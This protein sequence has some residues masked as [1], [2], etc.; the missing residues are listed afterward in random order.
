VFATEKD[1][2]AWPAIVDDFSEAFV[3]SRSERAKDTPYLNILDIFGLRLDE[4]S[5]S[6]I[7]E[8]FLNENGEHEQG[9]LFLKALA[10]HVGLN[11]TNF[12]GYHVQREKPDRVDVVV[13]K[14]DTFAI[15]IENKVRHTERKEQMAD[16]I[17]SIIKL[18]KAK[19]IPEK[20]RFA[21][22]LTDDGR[23]PTTLRT[24][25]PAGFI[26]KNLYSI[27]RVSLFCLFS[28]ALT[29]APIKSTLL[30]EFLGNYIQTI[31]H[32]P[33]TKI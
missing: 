23:S 3:Q 15:F 7:L 12:K 27:D 20:K 28:T 4:L 18:G 26:R 13:F 29:Q 22:F 2:L 17:D 31:A 10:N 16:L 24:N 30:L 33:G 6:R 32:H 9:E 21:I 1:S 25:I 11:A 19:G 8:W 14:K 5:H